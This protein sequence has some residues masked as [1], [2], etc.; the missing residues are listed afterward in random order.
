MFFYYFSL[1]YFLMFLITNKIKT[2]SHEKQTDWITLFTESVFIRVGYPHISIGRS[3][4]NHLICYV[5]P[6]VA[7]IL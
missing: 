2:S 6:L 1:K 7:T 5:L 4:L 3:R